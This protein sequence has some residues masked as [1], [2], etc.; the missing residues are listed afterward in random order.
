MKQRSITVITAIIFDMD[1]VLADSELLH[2]LASQRLLERYGVTVDEAFLRRYTGMD[3]AVFLGDVIREFGLDA[4]I[5]E[6]HKQRVDI[7]VGL[8]REQVEPVS[9]MEEMVRGISDLPVKR[10]L[11]SSSPRPVVMTILKKFDL[12]EWFDAVVTGDDVERGKPD[13]GIFL[14]AARQ[15][16]VSPADCIVVEDSKN[17]VAAAVAAGMDV[18]GFFNPNSGDQ[19]LSRAGRV[20]DSLEAIPGLI[21]ASAV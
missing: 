17:G 10:G 4:A 18:I 21:R 5:P 7:L 20:V 8:L 11:A 15:L 3:N 16:G 14:E 2:V 6:L 9:G 1:G 12:F 19:D 13:P